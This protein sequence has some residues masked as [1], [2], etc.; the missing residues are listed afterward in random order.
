MS[1]ARRCFRWIVAGLTTSM[2]IACTDLRESWFRDTAEA[3]TAGALATGWLPPFL[4]EGATEIWEIHR[5]DSNEWW[6]SFGFAAADAGSLSRAL[7]LLSPEEK[8]DHSNVRRPG[9]RAQWPEELTGHLSVSPMTKS[10]FQVF[11]H[12]DERAGVLNIA[13]SWK[14]RRAYFWRQS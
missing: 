7:T 1:R 5:I 9:G 13:V 8:L 4:P 14:A 11:R 12:V 3:R 10:G 6:G 2:A